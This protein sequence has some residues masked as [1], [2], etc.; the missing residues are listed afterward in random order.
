MMKWIL[1]QMRT[2]RCLCVLGVR[3]EMFSS[4]FLR[5]GCANV[6]RLSPVGWREGRGPTLQ[7]PAGSLLVRFP[8]NPRA[9]RQVWRNKVLRKTQTK[10]RAMTIV[11]SGSPQ[12]RLR[13]LLCRW[14]MGEWGL[15]KTCESIMVLDSKT[16]K[17]K[18]KNFIVSTDQVSLFSCSLC[19][20]CGVSFKGTWYD[21]K[22]KRPCCPTCWGMSV[23]ERDVS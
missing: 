18:Q 4:L 16:L 9:T 8:K 19:S 13:P 22:R 2:Y 11:E 3:S 21:K 10:A 7:T 1:H 5:E 23:Y 15:T 14:L 17:T 12:R 6:L 20:K